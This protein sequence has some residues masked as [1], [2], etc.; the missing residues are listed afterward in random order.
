MAKFD[1][2]DNRALW[3]AIIEAEAAYHCAVIALDEACNYPLPPEEIKELREQFKN[4]SRKHKE[5]INERERRRMTD[6][7][8]SANATYQAFK[9]IGKAK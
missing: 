7:E 4:A 5:L 6:G 9:A 1:H 3:A 8:I 2:L